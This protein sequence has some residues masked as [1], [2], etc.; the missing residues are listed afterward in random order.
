[1]IGTKII[2]PRCKKH[3]LVTID[4]P[5]KG[6]WESEKD[7]IRMLERTKALLTCPKCKF[8]FDVSLAKFFRAY[9]KRKEEFIFR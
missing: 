8:Q 9:K 6:P 1:M 4:L 2:C 7:Y 3:Y 5:S